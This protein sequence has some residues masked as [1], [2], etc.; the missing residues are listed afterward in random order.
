M[1]KVLMKI[2]PLLFFVMFT[3]VTAQAAVTLLDKEGMSFT[4]DA[5]FNTFYVYSSSDNDITG[6][7]RDQSRVKMGFLPNYIGFNFSKQLDNMKVG[8]RSSFWV[9]LK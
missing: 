1:K 9:T 3:A 5:F 8:G 7:D 6:V 4:T 2:L